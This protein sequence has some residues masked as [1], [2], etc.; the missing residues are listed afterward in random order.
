[1][2]EGIELE[3][4]LGRAAV[5]GAAAQLVLSVG[6]NHQACVGA[7]DDALEIGRLYVCLE[8]DALFAAELAV[9]GIGE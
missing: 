6:H 2:V 3:A 9:G 7:L 8:T 5:G 4:C 1:M